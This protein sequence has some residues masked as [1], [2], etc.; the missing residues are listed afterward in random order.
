MTTY[1]L[2]AT[3]FA[4]GGMNLPTAK[5]FN[6]P[7]LSAAGIM[8]GVGQGRHQAMRIN[9][10]VLVQGPDGSLHWYEFDAERSTIANPILRYV[11]P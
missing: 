7:D 3:G 5:V 9:D 8:T 11:G 10:Q 1:S 6:I 2:S 4:V